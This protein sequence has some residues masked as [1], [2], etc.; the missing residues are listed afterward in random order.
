[1]DRP[2]PRPGRRSPL[3]TRYLE[4]FLWAP[5]S[6]TDNPELIALMCRRYRD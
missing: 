5:P 4:D 2:A 6:R 3:R 1:M